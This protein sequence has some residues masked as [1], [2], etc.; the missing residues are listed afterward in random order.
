MRTRLWTEV[1]TV[2][3]AARPTDC[4]LSVGTGVPRNTALTDL[5][6][7]LS[8]TELISNAKGVIQNATDFVIGLISAATNSESTNILFKFLLDDYAPT[9]GKRKYFRLN[10][11]EVITKNANSKD[12]VD[13]STMDNAKAD[14]IKNMEKKTKEWIAKNKGL[15]DSTIDT[16]KSSLAAR[17][18]NQ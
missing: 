18:T 9:I 14:N 1:A 3:G 10:F 17:P 7:N 16:L 5:I 4:F 6:F 11:E 8:F 12:F 2:Y 13:L 15:V